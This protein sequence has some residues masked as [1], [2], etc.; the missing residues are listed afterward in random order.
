[1]SA[2][3]LRVGII[4]AGEVTQVIHLPVLSLLAHSYTVEIVCDISRKNAEHCAKK[5]QIPQATIE[6]ND[7]FNSKLVDVV[8]ILTSDEFHEEYTIAA[9]RHGKHVMLEKP[10]SL[11]IPSVQRMI[12]AEKEGNSRIFVGY[13]RRYAASFTEAFKREIA[14][15]PH[16]LYA[17]SRDFSGPNTQFV[18][19]SGT[20]PVKNTDFPPAAG[21]ER[22]KRLNKLFQEALPGNITEERKGLCRFLGSLGSHDISLMR[23]ALG[24]PE[25]I[26]GVSANGTATNTPFVTAI[27]NFRGPDGQPFA[28]TYESGIDK[29]PIFDAHLAVYGEHKRVYIDYES[30]YVKG[31]PIIVRVEELNAQ[32]EMVKR[33]ILSSYE[34]AYT[35]EL[36]EM[37]A[38]FTESKQIKTTIDDALEDLKIFDMMYNALD[39]STSPS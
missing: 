38:C 7:V 11:S 35:R 24:F 17:R 14:T 32:G 4:G 30:P 37:H 33:E 22:T 26:G 9:L 25:S 15:I 28:L 27:L 3:K 21:E 2:S 34:D 10:A 6:P 18:S 13:M 39:Q 19:Q 5:F 29:V 12:Q 36:T 31:L 1:M 8:F 20:F 16:I 23:E